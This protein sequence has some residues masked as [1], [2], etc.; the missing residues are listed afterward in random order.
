MR[1]ARLLV[2]FLA[3]CLSGLLPAQPASTLADPGQKANPGQ[4]ADPGQKAGPGQDG[5]A[6]NRTTNTTVLVT[7][8]SGKPAVAANGYFRWQPQV[9]FAELP[10]LSPFG[11][12]T[13]AISLVTASAG[14]RGELRV[15]AGDGASMSGF[16]LGVI[17]GEPAGAE[18]RSGAL[19]GPLW[20]GRA[21]RVALAPLGALGTASGSEPLVLHARA[22]FPDGS[23]LRLPPLQGTEIRLPAGSYELWAHAADGWTHA[24]IDLRPGVRTTLQW[25]GPATR[26]QP[27]TATLRLQP[28]QFALLDLLAPAGATNDTATV[29]CGAA[30]DAELVLRWQGHWLPWQ[31]GPATN[32]TLP[33]VGMSAPPA[34]QA[35]PSDRE[36]PYGTCY[37][38]VA[39]RGADGWQLLHLGATPHTLAAAP[40]GSFVLRHGGASPP[41]AVPW[42]PQQTWPQAPAGQG[43]QLIVRDQRKEPLASVCCDYT[44][45]GM[46][47]ARILGRSDALGRLHFGPVLAPGMLR[48]VDANYRNAT[49]ALPRIP[50]TPMEIVP[51]AGEAVHGHLLWPDDRPAADVLVTLREARG[52]LQPSERH[53][54]TAADGSFRFQG[55]NPDDHLVLTATVRAGAR[56]HLARAIGIVPGGAALQLRLRDEDPTLGETTRET[57]R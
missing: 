32:Q 1:M 18:Q 13:G 49:W 3:G 15:A 56:S 23:S 33:P 10:E 26:L 25:L 28:R 6:P 35:I 53:Q 27:R 39:P 44:P 37:A 46:P 17:H 9:A 38:T 48:L 50:T 51:E 7:D 43:L 16:A 34:M 8:A 42:A 19:V 5:P 36:D 14:T 30:R 52:Y 55:L 40:A 29:L 41:F 31:A 2:N 47:P 11:G 4:K 22:R 24:W 45:D 20:P 54:L 12:E 57:P 21:Q